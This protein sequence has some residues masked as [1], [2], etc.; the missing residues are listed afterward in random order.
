MVCDH[1]MLIT[2]CY[3]GYPGS[4]HDQR[5]FRQS[6]V[7]LYLNEEEKFPSDSHLVG[8][9]AYEL[10]EHLLVPFKD[11]GHL[12]AAQKYYNYCQ[13]SARVVIER[14]FALLKGRIRSLLYRLPMQR[15]DLISEYIIA[16]CVVHNICLLHEDEL[17]VVPISCTDISMQDYYDN[18]RQVNGIYKR[19]EIMNMLQRRCN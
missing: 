1:R 14:C 11:N 3:V 9:S 18:V 2:H 5:V 4:V 10:H 19:N 12:T 6:E 13:S 17:I 16:C 15:I 8:D 7:A